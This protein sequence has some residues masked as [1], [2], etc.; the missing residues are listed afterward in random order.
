ME[1]GTGQGDPRVQ[2]HSPKLHW[3]A[4]TYRVLF[5][6]LRFS[7]SVDAHSYSF[8]YDFYWKF[9]PHRLFIFSVC[10]IYRICWSLLCSAHTEQNT[11]EIH[12]FSLRWLALHSKL[13]KLYSYRAHIIHLCCTSQLII[14]PDQGEQPTT[15]LFSL[16]PQIRTP[17]QRNALM[18]KSR[19]K[20][21]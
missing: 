10:D 14:I 21:E 11:N 13:W 6:L 12:S 7:L 15:N 3:Y 16:V 4:H 20:T 19:K 1:W 9:S 8:I 17:S 5:S 18:C 2:L